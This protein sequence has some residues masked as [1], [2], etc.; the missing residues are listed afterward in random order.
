MAGYADGEF[1]REEYHGSVIPPADLGAALDRARWAIDHAI[2]F[3]I[4]DLSDW[5]AFVQRQV[6]LASCAQADHDH[7]Y[8]DMESVMGMIGGY[9][10][11][12][13]S[14]S[15]AGVKTGRA[16]LAEHYQLSEGAIRFLAPT[17]LLDRRLR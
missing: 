2:G 7:Q 8:G 14:V 17:G 16:A 11:G 6:K 5:S 1:Y 9:S 10:V 4:K 15:P 3:A 13:V 12:D